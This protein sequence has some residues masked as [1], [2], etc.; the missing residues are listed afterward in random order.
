MRNWGRVARYDR[1]SRI[2]N[3]WGCRLPSMPQCHNVRVLCEKYD[4]HAAKSYFPGEATTRAA[5]CVPPPWARK[6]V[7][8]LLTAQLRAPACVGTCATTVR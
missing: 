2:D 3:S 4:Y 7:P 6:T 5:S 8:S 1:G